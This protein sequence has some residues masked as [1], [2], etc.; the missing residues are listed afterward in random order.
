MVS[1]E[2]GVVVSDTAEPV[3]FDLPAGAELQAVDGGVLAVQGGDLLFVVTPTSG[4]LTIEGSAVVPDGVTTLAASTLLISK[5]TKVK[6]TKGTTYQVYPTTA[7][8]L[9]SWAA[10]AAFGWGDIKGMGVPDQIK[11]KHQYL[12]HIDSQVARVKPSW[13]LESWRPNVGYPATLAAG[14]NP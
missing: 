1:T 14:C 4:E 3:T 5:V 10:H 9:A 6:S 12:C 13:N 8:R 11:Y 2:D 7:G